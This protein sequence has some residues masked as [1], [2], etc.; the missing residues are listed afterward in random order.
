MLYVLLIVFCS[1]G[2]THCEW[3]AKICR[4]K[5]KGAYSQQQLWDCVYNSTNGKCPDLYYNRN[6]KKIKSWG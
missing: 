5:Y 3:I 2:M 6:R 4:D 1:D